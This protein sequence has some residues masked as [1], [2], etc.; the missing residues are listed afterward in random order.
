[1]KLTQSENAFKNVKFKLQKHNSIISIKSESIRPTNKSDGTIK[2]N[3][4]Y[5]VLKNKSNE[6]NF[7]SSKFSAQE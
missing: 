3:M 5:I 1:M 4:R 6:V 7:P 2:Y